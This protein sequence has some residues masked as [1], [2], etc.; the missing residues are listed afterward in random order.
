MVFESQVAPR[1]QVVLEPHVPGQ[2]LLRRTKDTAGMCTSHIAA[3]LRQPHS[4]AD[5]QWQ[6]HMLVRPK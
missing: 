2:P 3:V 4:L 6:R 5:V 1:P